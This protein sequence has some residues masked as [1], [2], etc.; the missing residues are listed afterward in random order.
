LQTLPQ[1]TAIREAQPD[2]QKFADQACNILQTKR[3]SRRMF[4]VTALR[5]SPSVA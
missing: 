1:L 4:P 2:L 5:H 3:R